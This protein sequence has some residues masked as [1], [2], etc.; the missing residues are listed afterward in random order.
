LGNLSLIVLLI[1]AAFFYFGKLVSSAKVVEYQKD[2]YY[3]EGFFFAVFYIA[4]PFIFIF[5]LQAVVQYFNYSINSAS[6]FVLLG[7]IVCQV[8]IS[9]L[10]STVVNVKRAKY[11]LFS[12]LNKAYKTVYQT[13]KQKKWFIKLTEEVAKIANNREGKEKFNVEKASLETVSKLA[14]IC[15]RKYVFI[16][17]VCLCLSVYISYTNQLPNSVLSPVVSIVIYFLSFFNF[18]LLAITYGYVNVDPQQ[19]SIYLNDGK[20]IIGKIV[21]MGKY[22]CV[23]KEIDE[24][25]IFINANNVVKIEYE[26]LK[27]PET[28]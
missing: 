2:D 3:I 1:V 26:L 19:A 23:I 16:F 5:A 8:I 27:P 20:P 9:S 13:K 17:S 4:I 10:L 11:K 12:K 24:K 7:I 15:N 6:V 25:T 14:K 18:T 21:K 22:I 28:N